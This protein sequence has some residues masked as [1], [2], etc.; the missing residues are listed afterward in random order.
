MAPLVVPPLAQAAGV[1]HVVPRLVVMPDDPALGEFRALFAGRL[2]TFEEFPTPASDRHPGFH[3]ATEIL[4]TDKLWPRLL[5]NA[6]ERIDAR[7]FLRARLFDILIGDW[8]RHAGQWRWARLPDK[9]GWQPLPEDRDWAFANFEGLLIGLVRPWQPTLMTFR[10]QYPSMTGLTLHGWRLLRWVL[11]E[12]EKSAWDE[13]AADIHTA[14]RQM[15]PAYQTLIGAELAAA[16]KKR[17]DR[18]PEVA[19]RLYRFLATQVDVQGTDQSERIELRRLGP[20]GVQV[21]ITPKRGAGTGRVPYFWRRFRSGET[22]ELRLYLREGADTVAC[23]GAVGN[24]MTI[25][26]IGRMENDA[27][28]GCQTARLR[29]ADAAQLQR[30]PPSVREEPDPRRHFPPVPT[31]PAP[32]AKPRDWGMHLLP[33]IWFNIG[34][35]YG[36]LLG[37]GLSLD[38]FGFGKVPYAQR[39]VLRG[40]YAFGVEEFKIEYQGFFRHR[41]PALLSS[42]AASISGIEVIRFYGF[43]NNT[44]SDAPDDFFKTEQLQFT[45]APSVRYALASQLDLFGGVQVTY[46]TT[47]TDANTLLNQLQPYGVGD[48]GQLRFHV[49]VDVDTRDRTKVYGP[50]LRVRLQG[51]FFPEVWDVE[52]SFGTL[53]VDAAGH[54]ALNHRLLLALRLSGKY[55]FGTFPFHEAAYVGGSRTVRGYCSDRFAGDASLFGSTELRFLLGKATFLVPAEWGLFTFGDVGRVFL[56]G[57]SSETWHPAGGGG[58]FA[59]ILDRSLLLALSVARSDERTV[60]FLKTEF[61]F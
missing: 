29:F 9:T 45:L 10:E 1:L 59:S 48:F 14:V 35:D 54:L 17:R 42:L 20:G 27:I 15:P 56:D 43:G 37:G 19:E 32:W 36:L 2:G 46:A 57:E 58:L 26:V 39:H 41:N 34:S 51:T 53:E 8:D 22:R 3:G 12:L 24:N 16:L 7:A 49:G 40:G 30:R 44:S 11:P 23:D 25:H 21:S 47:D 61:V 33:T 4:S 31:L 50:G 28:E 5:A 52:S 6:A 60:F 18:L 13:V 55:V 38:R